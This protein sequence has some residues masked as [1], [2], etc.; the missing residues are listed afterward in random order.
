MTSIP[1]AVALLALTLG[2]ASAPEAP[3]T[4]IEICYDPTFD[5]QVPHTPI[6]IDG[7]NNFT[8]ANGVT[9]GSGTYPDPYLL[10]NWV[11]GTSSQNAIEIRNTSL[12]FEIRGTITC[13]GFSSYLHDGLR[14]DNVTNAHISSFQAAYHRIHVAI[15]NS[16]NVSFET[17]F[18]GGVDFPDQGSVTAVYVWNSSQVTISNLDDSW[19]GGSVAIGVH[20]AT[21]RNTR[22]EYSR[23]VAPGTPISFD[24][25][26]GISLVSNDVRGSN[27]VS[28][29]SSAGVLVSD[30]AFN[31]CLALHME[32][33]RNVQ[34]LRSTFENDADG[35]QLMSVVNATIRGNSFGPGP[36]DY[37]GGGGFTSISS[38]D[39]IVMDNEF[40]HIHFGAQLQGSANVSVFHNIF[41]RILYPAFDDRGVENRW[42]GG[43]PSGGN[44]WSDYNGTDLRNGPGQ[45]Q[46]GNDGIGDK[47]YVI[48]GDS[49]DRYPWVTRWGPTVDN[50][51]VDQ[52]DA[53]GASPLSHQFAV[54]L[55]SPIL[56]A[57]RAT[58]IQP[59]P[60]FL[61]RPKG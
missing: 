16:T 22:V 31:W 12:P 9:G 53:F 51:T 58:P 33:F 27:G 11:I 18:V 61:P 50:A 34:V 46:M 37:Y 40:R 8:A 49:R 14:L 1:A 43:Y 47:P 48:D 56:V 32:M 55:P 45:D 10:D 44:Y 59:R 24:H 28:G 60:P 35:L 17:G 21:V 23:L 13:G 29:S 2:I 26:Q 54:G 38:R 19:G 42:D 30:N 7:D 36:T 3:H 4:R 39:L 20:L 41:D 6:L 15:E 25:S 5:H 57:I 52:G